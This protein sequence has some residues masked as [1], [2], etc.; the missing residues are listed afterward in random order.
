MHGVSPLSS[1]VIY[2]MGTAL[3]STGTIFLTLDDRPSLLKMF[4]EE[5]SPLRAVPYPDQL[6]QQDDVLHLKILVTSD[7]DIFSTQNIRF[8]S[9]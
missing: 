5:D 8:V 6:F 9:R 3:L 7:Y 4:A 1:I 2:F